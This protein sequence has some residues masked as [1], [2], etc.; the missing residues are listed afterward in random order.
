MRG[1]MVVSLTVVII[2]LCIC[3]SS[4]HVLHLKYIQFSL[5]KKKER[6]YRLQ[7]SDVMQNRRAGSSR[8]SPFAKTTTKLGGNDQ[9]QQLQNLMYTLTHTHTRK[10]IYAYIHAKSELFPWRF[11]FRSG[12]VGNLHSRCFLSSN[13]EVENAAG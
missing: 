4:H 2:S 13:K 3:I 10:N 7:R 9:N 6:K 12:C 11:W 1:E 5:K 8:V